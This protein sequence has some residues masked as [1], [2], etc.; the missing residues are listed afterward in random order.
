MN[1]ISISYPYTT[2]AHYIL[3]TLIKARRS[4]VLS[5]ASDA[6]E[7]KRLVRLKKEFEESEEQEAHLGCLGA[8][9]QVKV[10]GFRVWV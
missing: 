1:I 8:G 2:I 4:C 7:V 5:F 3:E 9:F 10:V 6:S